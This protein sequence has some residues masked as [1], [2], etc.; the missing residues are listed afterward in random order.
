MQSLSNLCAISTQSRFQCNLI[1]N[2]ISFSMQS[3]S[4]FYLALNA[5]SLSMQSLCNLYA[6]SIQSLF[7]LYAISMQSTRYLRNLCNLYAHFLQFLELPSWQSTNEFN[8]MQ[9]SE[10]G[11]IGLRSVGL[12]RAVALVSGI[13][14]DW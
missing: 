2:A 1:L 8:S 10:S 14:P 3:R 6:I 4:Q 7:N 13:L 9:N 12:T 5:I 11:K